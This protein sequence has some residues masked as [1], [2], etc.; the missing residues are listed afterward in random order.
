MLK[1]VPPPLAIAAVNKAP[2]VLEAAS[3]TVECRCGNCGDVL[4]RVDKNRA[5]PLI[6]HCTAC[7]AFNSTDDDL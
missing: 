3:P 4:M 6:V 7:D 5:N 1:V 2:P